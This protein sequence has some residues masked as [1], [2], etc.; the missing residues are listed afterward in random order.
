MIEN[1]ESVFPGVR[2]G[3]H[4]VVYDGINIGEGSLVHDFV[5]LG[6]PPRGRN[7]GELQT[8]IG[9]SA[10]IRPFT[11]I[12]AGSEIGDSLETGKGASIRED[13]VL[14]DRVSLGTNSVL[15]FGNRIGRNVRI[16]SSCFLEMVTVGNDVFIGPGT[17]FTDDP[18]PMGCPRYRE[19]LGGARVKSLARVGAGCIIL[20]GVT[21]GK[22]SLVGAG[23]LVTKD[24][25]DDTVVAGHPA[26]VIKG[27]EELVCKPGFYE[28]PYVWPPYEM[29]E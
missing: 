16:H 3:T 22:N 9:N 14:A 15:E 17:V 21:I 27:I 5:V 1:P 25:P 24:V 20:P 23:S 29:N 26:R 6:L 2:F 13:N 8:R 19:C 18:H 7:P 4:C 10:V 11:V 12:Y 28:R